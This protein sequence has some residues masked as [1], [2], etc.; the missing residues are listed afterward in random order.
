MSLHD[1]MTQLSVGIS[2]CILIVIVTVNW[3]AILPHVYAHFGIPLASL[4]VNVISHYK[5]AFIPIVKDHPL[6]MNA[7]IVFWKYSLRTL[8][9]WKIDWLIDYH[10]QP[11][12]VNRAAAIVLYEQPFLAASW[13]SCLHLRLT[14]A[15]SLVMVLCNVSLVLTEQQCKWT[16][17]YYFNVYHKGTGLHVVAPCSGSLD[18][19]N[20]DRGRK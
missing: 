16:D 15:V 4:H 11:N 3:P 9:S 1:D 2:G 13:I 18:I 20:K 10:F 12:A 19:R 6:H 14:V 5:C 8:G 7:A 17:L